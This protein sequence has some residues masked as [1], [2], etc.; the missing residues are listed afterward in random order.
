MSYL[1]IAITI[2]IGKKIITVNMM[3]IMMTKNPEDIATEDL[4]IS[5]VA[6][7]SVAISSAHPDDELIN[8][9]NMMLIMMMQMMILGV[10]SASSTA[11][12][13][14]NPIICPAFALIPSSIHTITMIVMMMMN[15]RMI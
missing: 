11:T 2:V 1:N 4:A 12:C 3:M 10:E 15:M 8:M 9:M 14:A 7:S 5:S 13:W 6:K